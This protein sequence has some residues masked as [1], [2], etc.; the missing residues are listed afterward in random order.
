M[1]AYTQAVVDR[2]RSEVPILEVLASLGYDVRVDHSDREQ[3]FRCD[4]H[5]SSHDQK[6]SARVYPETNSWYC[7]GCGASRDAV[8]TVKVKKSLDFWPAVRHLERQF[9]LIPLEGEEYHREDL[10][11]DVASILDKSDSFEMESGR[12]KALL[13]SVTRARE[14]PLET[15]LLYWE[16]YDKV[17][18]MHHKKHL[19][20]KEAIHKMAVLRHRVM[21]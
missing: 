3:Q 10:R 19:S 6:P 11:Q 16:A 9:G 13:E 1:S 17:E 2:I 4:L 20:E 18:W 5:G 12:V 14:H 15:L 7:W 8:E 21:G